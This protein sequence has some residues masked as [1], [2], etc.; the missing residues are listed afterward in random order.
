MS[1]Q[2]LVSVVTSATETATR[3]Y[4]ASKVIET[5]RT[6]GKKLRGQVERV[7][8]TLANELATHGDAKRAKQ[9]AS[10][11]KKHLPAVLWSGTF[12]KRSN[13]ALIQHSGLLC[14]DLDSLGVSLADVRWKL[15]QSPHVW[16][17]F[18]SPSGG[19]LKAVFRVPP[20]ATKH[21][22][23]YR[24]I[25]QHVRFLTGAEVDQACKDVARLC[26]LS[27]DPDVYH[28]ANATE[29]EPLPEPE[30]T[31]HVNNGVVNLS[32][33]QRIVTG[34]LGEVDWQLETSGFVACPVSTFTRAAITSGIAR[35]SWI[36]FQTSIASTTLVAA[37]WRA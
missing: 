27:F 33:R 24:A 31:R 10:E 29:I 15:S 21:S 22:G 26:F 11:P 25:E 35:L 13:D 36:M 9:A 28:N 3:D 20:D 7:R 2:I 30:K 17:L 1:D 18:Q 5:I 34:I 19:G 8:N 6:G 23:S 12:T 16:A 32:D 14:A 4:N 37:S